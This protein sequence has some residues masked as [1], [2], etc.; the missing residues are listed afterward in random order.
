MVVMRTGIGDDVKILA[1]FLSAETSEPDVSGQVLSFFSDVKFTVE[2]GALSGQTPVWISP[3]ASFRVV[4]ERESGKLEGWLQNTRFADYLVVT[5]QRIR[6]PLEF[7]NWTPPTEIPAESVAGLYEGRWGAD[8]ATIIVKRLAADNFAATVYG[9]DMTVLADFTQ[10][11]YDPR[12]G[13]ISLTGPIGS[14]VQ[15]RKLLMGLKEVVDDKP[16]F[17]GFQ[18]LL[19]SPAL[20]ETSFTRVSPIISPS[21]RRELQIVR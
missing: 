7:A 12:R 14:G 15:G 19:D 9:A 8:A 4:V 1:N 18:I 17:Q 13:V 6:S 11:D 16:V 21:K 20:V 10:G 5:G 3:S 2:T